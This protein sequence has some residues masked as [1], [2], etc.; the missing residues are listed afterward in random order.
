M[1]KVMIFILTISLL[2]SAFTAYACEPNGIYDDVNI[3][4][5]FVPSSDYPI[6]PTNNY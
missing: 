2:L 6:I 5:E 4:S 3:N 1:K